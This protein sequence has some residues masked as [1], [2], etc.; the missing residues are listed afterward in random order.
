VL[1]SPTATKFAIHLLAVMAEHE[2][3]AIFARTKPRL[4][5]PRTKGKKLAATIGA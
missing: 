5:P 1:R 4:L 2:R 3:D